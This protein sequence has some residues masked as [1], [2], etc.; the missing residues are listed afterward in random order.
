MLDHFVICF[1]ILVEIFALAIS[2][3]LFHEAVGFG[4]FELETEAGAGWLD[5]MLLSHLIM[6]WGFFGPWFMGAGQR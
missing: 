6:A 4:S 3:A 2:E 1:Y 5:E